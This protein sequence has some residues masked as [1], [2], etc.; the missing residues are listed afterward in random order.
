MGWF[1]LNSVP[2]GRGGSGPET[3][4]QPYGLCVFQFQ[5]QFKVYDVRITLFSPR[6]FPFIRDKLGS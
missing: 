3:R 6:I 1:V 2:V 4:Y 5:F